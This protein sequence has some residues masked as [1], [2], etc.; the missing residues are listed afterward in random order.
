MMAPMDVREEIVYRAHPDRVFE[1]LCDEAF[2]E[3]VCRAVG[4]VSCEVSVSR[5][6]DTAHVRNHRVMQADLPDVARRVVGDTI[7][8]V[9]IEDWAARGADGARSADFRLEIP[10]KPGHVTGTVTISPEGD[11]T[12]EVIT[13]QVKVSIPLVGRKLEAEVARAMKAAL[14]VEGRVG[15]TWLSDGA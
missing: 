7:E 3:K 13:G 12:R 1:M 9:Q 6:G 10:G 15:A 4:S 2:R 8:L 5:N 14:E 11:T